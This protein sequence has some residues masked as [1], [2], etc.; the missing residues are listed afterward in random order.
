MKRAG[1]RGVSIA[2][3]APDFDATLL[4]TSF[5]SWFPI[6]DD[7]VITVTDSNFTASVS[8]PSASETGPDTS[9][10]GVLCVGKLPPIRPVC[11]M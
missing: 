1:S 6:K 10:I 9:V 8:W 2:R 7:F 5:N 11:A 4:G 3:G